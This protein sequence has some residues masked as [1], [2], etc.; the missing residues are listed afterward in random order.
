[1]GPSKGSY[2]DN[3]GETY[4]WT[5]PYVPEPTAPRAEVDERLVLPYGSV[6]AEWMQ[7]LIWFQYGSGIFL[8][9]GLPVYVV[10]AVIG[11]GYYNV[12][13]LIGLGYYL[14]VQWFGEMVDGISYEA[15]QKVY[16][17]AN[18]I[19]YPL[20]KMF[21]YELLMIVGMYCSVFPI[22]NLWT[23]PFLGLAAYYNELY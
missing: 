9:V 13:N 19:D 12:I 17:L 23:M 6:S 10:L 7:W 5:C 14:R 3:L 21:L 16:T 22:T 18:Y 15:D 4:A 8:V 1:M 11:W 20:R 2:T